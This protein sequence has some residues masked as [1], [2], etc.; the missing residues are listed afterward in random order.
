MIAMKNTL[1]LLLALGGFCL[2]AQIVT[3]KLNIHSADTQCFDGNLFCFTDSILPFG[4]LR[5]S[6]AVYLFSDGSKIERINPVSDT[7]RFCHSFKDPAGGSYSLTV[8]IT[9]TTGQILKQ[10]YT[11]LMTVESCQTKME[12]IRNTSIMIS[13]VNT[14]GHLLL[15]GTGLKDL[16]ARIYDLSGRS[17]HF[18]VR[19]DGDQLLLQ[20][21]ALSDSWCILVL[22]DKAG[23]AVFRQLLH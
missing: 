9:D 21:D 22:Y 1:L 4:T 8:E 2:R 13:V 14:A 23:N 19:E 10:T 16:K 5:V 11:N 17:V 18:T 6:K 15:S 7:I 20:S 3:H 12:A